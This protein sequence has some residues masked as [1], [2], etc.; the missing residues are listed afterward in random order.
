METAARVQRKQRTIREIK[1]LPLRL[2][3]AFAPGEYTIGDA[4]QIKNLRLHGV[5]KIPN[6]AV[7]PICPSGLART[8]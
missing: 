2:S 6:I 4:E 1:H 7:T 8:I 3:A 5:H